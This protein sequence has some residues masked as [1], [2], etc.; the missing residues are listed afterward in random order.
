MLYG[1]LDVGRALRHG[2]ISCGS[3]PDYRWRRTD[4]RR[5]SSRK[6]NHQA[7]HSAV[8]NHKTQ[9]TNGRPF[10]WHGIGTR[11]A[12]FII[13]LPLIIGPLPP[14]LT[15]HCE[16]SGRMSSP[17]GLWSTRA[18][19]RSGALTKS[20]RTGADGV[21]EIISAPPFVIFEWVRRRRRR[22]E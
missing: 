10:A 4:L 5:Q 17:N 12:L 22:G 9:P 20:H 2:L 16:F 21:L 11:W 18:A 8:G 7:R 14:R 19:R 3:P 13:H 1:Y 6:Q 15:G